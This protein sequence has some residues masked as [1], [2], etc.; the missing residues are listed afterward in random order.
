MLS[1]LRIEKITMI[2]IRIIISLL[3]LSEA[4]HDSQ[5]RN[6]PVSATSSSN[7]ASDTTWEF[8]YGLDGWAQA[9]STEMDAEVYHM[10]GEM[11]I[12][13]LSPSLVNNDL[14][15]HVDSPIMSIPIGERETLAMRYRFVGPSTFGKIRL[16]GGPN[17]PV[18]TDHGLLD[19]GNDEVSHDGFVNVYFPIIGDGMWHIGYAE[20]ENERNDVMTKLNGTITQIRLWPG[21]HHGGFSIPPVEGNSFNV[22]WIRLVRA[23]VINKVTGCAGEK[24]FH[25]QTMTNP[26][27]NIETDN[28]IINQVLHHFRTVWIRRQTSHPYSLT[29]NCLRRG[30][31]EITIEGHNFGLGG[32]NGSGAP[33]HVY[34]DGKPCTYV[35]HDIDDPQ[36]KLTCI[37]P[38]LSETIQNHDHYDKSLIELRNGKLTGLS[39]MSTS[40]IYA[41]SPPK[42]IMI[43][44]SN[45]A[46][47]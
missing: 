17:I 1:V 34:I 15:A 26:Q 2:T 37:T 31:E 6:D 47:R 24:Y 4:A 16:R 46:S 19:W 45:F 38:V 7:I 36:R 27:F 33:A 39:D 23:P 18:V 32:V 30:G 20:I 29:Y 13:I 14:G 35:K 42:P 21:H 8:K 10:G 9:T 41:R 22:D 40:L 12:K 43:F 44:L 25:D 3:V 28:S 11:R 5:F